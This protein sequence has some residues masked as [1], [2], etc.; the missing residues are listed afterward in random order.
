MTLL[1]LVK[2]T[3]DG[4]Y[5]EAQETYSAGNVDAEIQKRIAYLSK[6]Y[7]KLKDAHRTPI[8]YRDPATRFAYVCKYV[9]AH[10]DYIVQ[11]LA[12]TKDELGKVFENAKARVTCVGGGP[13]SDILAVLKYLDD[14][15]KKEAVDKV[16]FYLL[17]KEQAWADTWTELED[18]FEAAVGLN[19]YFQTMDVTDPESW[20]LQKKSLDSNIFTISYFAS[21]VYSLDKDGVVSAFW[22]SLFKNA[23]PGALFLYIDNG[24]DDF[25]KYFDALWKKAGLISLIAVDNTRWTPRHTEQASV[26]AAYKAKFG[27]MSKLQGTLSVRVLRKPK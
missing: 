8:D 15:G 9:A 21:E 16:T 25:N 19:S 11:L 14:Y 17:D 23:K 13:G 24:T 10:G 4:L 22:A 12:L 6:S 26:L 5:K 20:T 3:L 1:E 27:E 2:I 7:G 18:S